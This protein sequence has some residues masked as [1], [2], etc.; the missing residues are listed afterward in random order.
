MATLDIRNHK[1]GEITEIK[2]DKSAD[3][4]EKSRGHLV[5][6]AYGE[7]SAPI[8]EYEDLDNFI[9]ACKKTKELW[10]K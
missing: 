8:C 10:G 3:V 7:D 1:D 9:A 4:I 6:R 2:F 5:F